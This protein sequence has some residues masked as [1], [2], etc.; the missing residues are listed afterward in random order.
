MADP[1]GPIMSRLA[2]EGCL[3]V[4]VGDTVHHFSRDDETIEV[5]TPGDLSFGPNEDTHGEHKEAHQHFA[6]YDDNTGELDVTVVI[7]SP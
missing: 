4:K 5:R 6:S 3:L 7:S 1:P 2:P